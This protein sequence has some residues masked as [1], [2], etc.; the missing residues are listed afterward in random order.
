MMI[1]L[2]ILVIY[3]GMMILSFL[4]PYVD[5]RKNK[6]EKGKKYT[7][8]DLCESMDEEY[9]IIC[10]I[11]GVN[12]ITALYSLGYLLIPPVYNIIKKIRII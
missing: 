3:I 5:F 9:L 6:C 7:F 4:G 8:G 11:P 12:T 1:L 10:F 2:M